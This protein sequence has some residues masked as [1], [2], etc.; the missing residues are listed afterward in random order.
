MGFIDMQVSIYCFCDVKI[1]FFGYNY[2]QFDNK[3]HNI[4]DLFYLFFDL[5]LS[6]II[7]QQLDNEKFIVFVVCFKKFVI[8]LI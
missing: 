8:I 1:R 7:L 6:L 5:N 2:K 3:L 4:I